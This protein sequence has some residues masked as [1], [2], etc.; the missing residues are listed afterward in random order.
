VIRAFRSEWVKLRRRTLLVSTYASLTALSALFTVLV[1]TRASNNPNRGGER[2]ISLAELARPDGLSRG[3]TRAALLLGVVAFGIAASQV[4]FEFSLGTLRQLLVR[5]PRRTVLLS[6]KALG[7]IT[8]LAGAVL[9]S[10]IGGGAA[11]FVM[12]GVRGISTA[13]WTSST[14]IADIG[15][16][17]GD[18][19]LAVTG[20]GVLGMLAGLIL[21]SPAPAAVVGFVYLLPFE[22]IFSAVVKGS[23]RWLPGQVL[24]AISEG[25]TANLTF[26]RGLMTAT[27]YTVIAAALGAV[28]FS[29]RDVTA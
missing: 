6:G 21:R 1:F 5:Q 25:G 18:V 10:G 17:L 27:A 24:A 4:A 23:D 20:Y 19:A 29:K 13:A 7:I 15:H 28:L 9:C 22:G 2:F 14:G 26:S 16:A 12:A 8:F 11:A 3:L